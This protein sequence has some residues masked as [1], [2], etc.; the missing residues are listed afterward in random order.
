[1]ID[2]GVDEEGKP[3]VMRD[4]AL[5]E[6]ILAVNFDNTIELWTCQS[7]KFERTGV[8]IT[9]SDWCRIHIVQRFSQTSL[10]IAESTHISYH[11]LSDLSLTLKVDEN[12]V[13]SIHISP[14]NRIMISSFSNTTRIYDL[15]TGCQILT[16]SAISLKPLILTSDIYLF[17]DRK[18]I[19][20][21]NF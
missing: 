15:E 11:N 8:K 21:V 16:H 9:V 18:N 2:L 5:H 10:L 12:K 4:F 6:K 7:D 20:L 13:D 14:C 19:S 3:L 17:T 1:V